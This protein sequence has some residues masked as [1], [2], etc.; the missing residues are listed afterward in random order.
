MKNIVNL[1]DLSL[2][3]IH[4]L[5]DEAI[6]F[7]NGKT[8]DYHQK[9][10]VANLFFEPSTRTHYSFDMA[11]GNLGC[12]TQNF[13]ASNSS[14]KKGETLYDTCKLF[15]SIG[16]DALVIRHTDD[17]YYKQLEG[18]HIP[19]LNAG[20]GKGNHPSQSLLDLMTIKEEFGHFEGLKVVIV[21]DI[22]H[23]RVA[24]SNYDVMQRLGMQVYTSGPLEY[25]QDGYNYVDFDDVIE[26]MD[27]VM[28]LRVQHERHAGDEDFSK[29]N[30]HR[31]YG[32]S[33]ERYKRLKETAIIMHPAPINRDVEI[34]DELVESGKSRIFR[35]MHNGVF[36]R[37]AMIHEVLENE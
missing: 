7:K 27:V 19:I 16:C 36:I 37:M 35:Q 10:V 28:L 33:L 5:I 4:H 32:L 2:E 17:Y 29:E 6:A 30:Y 14:L 9:K 18:I 22:L 21:G 34:K 1:S 26:D 31:I 24:H 20:D 11:A 15:E 3:Q 23:S 25:K 8:V 13:E 12:R